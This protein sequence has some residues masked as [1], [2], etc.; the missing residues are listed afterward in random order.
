MVAD[1]IATSTV[2]D[3]H[4][5]SWLTAILAGTLAVVIAVCVPET[6]SPVLLAYRETCSGK[7]KGDAAVKSKSSTSTLFSPG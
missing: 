3:W 1:F 7:G 2:M 6:Y 4:W 5:T